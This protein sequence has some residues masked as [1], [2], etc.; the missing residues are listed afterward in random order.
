MTFW[1]W[2][3]LSPFLPPATTKNVQPTNWL[4][5]LHTIIESPLPP[6]PC[7]VL[8][9]LLHIMDNK[10][11]CSVDCL[12]K[13]A[14]CFADCKEREGD[15]DYVELRFEIWTITQIS[16]E[17]GRYVD[18][19]RLGFLGWTTNLAKPGSRPVWVEWIR[20]A[21]TLQ[22][23]GREACAGKM[24]WYSWDVEIKDIILSSWHRKENKYHMHFTILCSPNLPVL[25]NM[26]L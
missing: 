21:L 26:V 16:R 20:R 8:L 25:Y 2:R 13:W 22:P 18:M 1:Q 6:S 17:G 19:F 23:E 4:N 7:F 10:Q 24:A 12:K 14:S 15:G 5:C 11:L 9:L 3:Y